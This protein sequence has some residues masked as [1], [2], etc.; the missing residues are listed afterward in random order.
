MRYRLSRKAEEDIIGI[1]LIGVE[2]FGMAQAERYHGQLEKCF[3]FLAD[4]PLAAHERHEIMPPVR[5]HPVGAHLVI[6]RIEDDGGI[7]VIRVRHGHEDWQD[8]SE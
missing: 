3:R 8:A 1:F 7:F 6:Y 5:I 4:N 2:R